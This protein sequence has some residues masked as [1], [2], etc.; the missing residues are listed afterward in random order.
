MPTDLS[1]LSYTESIDSH[2]LQNLLPNDKLEPPPPLPNSYGTII[3]EEKGSFNVAELVITPSY[4][5]QAPN[6]SS[7]PTSVC[8]A[9]IPTYDSLSVNAHTD[10]TPSIPTPLLDLHSLSIS[11]K[12]L[13]A[14]P[15]STKVLDAVP[16]SMQMIMDSVQPMSIRV[17]DIVSMPTQVEDTVS[18]PTQVENTVL[19]PTQVE[20]T[21]SMPLQDVD[22]HLLQS[23]HK[24]KML[25]H[26]SCR[27]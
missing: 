26:Y 3:E 27:R 8:Y 1:T 19:M 20:D 6:A 23:P 25:R 18:M 7:E 22:L 17:E 9:S 5:V 15:E 4:E 12:V 2:P 16:E 13:D 21:V 11:T 10:V 24:L 14:V